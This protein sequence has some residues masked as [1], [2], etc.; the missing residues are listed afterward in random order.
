MRFQLCWDSWTYNLK[1]P[2]PCDS[3]K[4][5]QSYPVVGPIPQNAI[6]IPGGFH[7]KSAKEPT[8]WDFGSRNRTQPSI[9]IQNL[10]A[11]S[12]VGLFK[13]VT[14]ESVRVL[15]W[16]RRRRGSTSATTTP[17]PPSTSSAPWSTPSTWVGH[18]H[19]VPVKSLWVDGRL[20][21]C[22]VRFHASLL[23]LYLA[24]WGWTQKTI[25]NHA[26]PQHRHLLWSTVY[27]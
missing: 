2:T 17:G 9:K 7:L 14:S 24:R 6:L 23:P 22:S 12:Y 21:N 15:R 8:P 25:T 4:G 11:A 1:E 18:L 5:N 27:F 16:R 13:R 10:A 3:L 26:M 20:V 19:L